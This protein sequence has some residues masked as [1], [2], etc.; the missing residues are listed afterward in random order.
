M[1]R[2]GM[3]ILAFFVFFGM[4]MAR[5]GSDWSSG[6]YQGS[7]FAVLFALMFG[8]CFAAIRQDRTHLRAAFLALT[9]IVVTVQPNNLIGLQRA[10]VYV[11][12]LSTAE[13]L[14]RGRFKGNADLIMLPP[15]TI[16]M[17]RPVDRAVLTAYWQAWREHQLDA[18]VRNQP[19][20]VG[21][22]YL[23][24]ELNYLDHLR[25]LRRP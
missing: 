4:C 6:F 20:P 12:G 25:A 5:Q 21:A 13:S 8:V 1:V 23:I 17:D 16:D 18:S 22:L 15:L 9:V 2:V 10:W 11:I 24:A 14:D 3:A 7:V 19:V